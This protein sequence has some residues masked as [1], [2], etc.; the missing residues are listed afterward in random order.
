MG[1]LELMHLL[2]LGGISVVVIVVISQQIGIRRELSELF[3]ELLDFMPSNLDAYTALE[4][5]QSLKANREVTEQLDLYIEAN[6]HLAPNFDIIKDIVERTSSE[7]DDRVRTLLSIP[8]YYGLCGTILG[9]ILGIIPLVI[10]TSDLTANMSIL[11]GGV[12]IAMLGSLVGILITSTS[13]SRY[14]EVS[15]VHEKSKRIFFNWFQVTQLPV[16][17]S[18]PSGPIGQLIRSL[19]SFNQDFASSA[20]LMTN[21][22]KEISDTFKT[23]KELL[24]L[25]KELANPAVV[26]QNVAMAQQMGHHVDVVRSFNNS[27]LGMQD[28]VDKLQ[29]V[30]A[31]L[32]SS[33]QY[34]QVV[35]QLVA[36]LNSEREAIS[37]AT[38]G[39]AGHIRSVHSNQQQL[40]NG[41]LETIKTQNDIVV[42]EFKSHLDSTA[43][44][45]RQ[46][47]SKH[48]AFPESLIE[49]AKLPKVLEEVKDSLKQGNE[50][51]E[52]QNA[53]LEAVSKGLLGELTNIQGDI[54]QMCSR[55]DN[56]KLDN[57]ERVT[58]NNKRIQDQVVVPKKSKRRGF[59]GNLKHRF[60]DFTNK[61]HE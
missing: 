5:Y 9:V 2:I 43:L 1:Y 50:T 18:N 47:L 7:L 53:K 26:Q 3:K 58:L 23:Q 21:T 24:T 19:Y 10:D 51:R 54:K 30:T 40:I 41:S 60:L 20:N 49:I 12:A 32:Q 15:K 36:I 29:G 31:S 56:L 14:K 33:T 17:G 37:Q 4:N 25:M 28:Y 16:I 34:L 11:L 38:G 6:Q 61:E 59:W 39:L 46:H 35:E 44:E 27:I 55:L 45:L 42:K 13:Y 57:Q 48:P 22:A 52:K 8:L